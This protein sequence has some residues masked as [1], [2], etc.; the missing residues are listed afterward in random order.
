M[1]T[2]RRHKLS[3]KPGPD[4]LTVQQIEERLVDEARDAV[5]AARLAMENEITQPISRSA[6]T[7]LI[8]GGERP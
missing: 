2:P 6:L 5:E 3:K 8:E 4:A 7:A 1:T